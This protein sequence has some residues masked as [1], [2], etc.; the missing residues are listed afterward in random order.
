MF[1]KF[2]VIVGTL[3]NFSN[4]LTNQIVAKRLA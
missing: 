2:V 3:L 4:Y 1:P